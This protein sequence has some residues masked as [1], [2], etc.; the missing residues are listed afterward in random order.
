VIDEKDYSSTATH[1][2]NFSVGI[3]VL[4]ILFAAAYFVFDKAGQAWDW[5]KSRNG[6][7]TA[8]TEPVAPDGRFQLVSG[9]AYALALDTKTGELCHTFNEKIDT[10]VPA[11]GTQG[12]ETVFGHQALDS[13][14]L[15][16]DLSQNEKAAIAKVM[17]ADRIERDVDDDPSQQTYKVMGADGKIHDFD[18]E[19]D[20]DLYRM[21][22]QDSK[23][24]K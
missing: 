11:T 19:L 12:R 10:Y 3:T 18:T 8:T 7:S 14:P 16:V 23:T 21:K 20:A 2:G 22:L 24:S 5:M 1:F 9:T 13:I 15:C 6:A 4:V 17:R